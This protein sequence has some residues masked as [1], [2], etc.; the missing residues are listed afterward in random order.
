MTMKSLQEAINVELKKLYGEGQ[1]FVWLTSPQ[2][3]LGLRIPAR[4]IA[5]GEG[6]AVLDA[7]L[8]ANSQCS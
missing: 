8:N 2:E 5:I 7:L 4:M 1:A 3:L 6:R